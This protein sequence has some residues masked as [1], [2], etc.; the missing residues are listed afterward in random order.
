MIAY[1]YLFSF[2]CM[3]MFYINYTCSCFK[4]LTHIII[5]YWTKMH[6]YSI[7]KTHFLEKLGSKWYE[8]ETDVEMGQ[9]DVEMGLESQIWFE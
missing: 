6:A 7:L 9:I 1:T 8:Q 3:C 2:V 4:D 5:C